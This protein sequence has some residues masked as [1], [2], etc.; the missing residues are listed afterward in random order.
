LLS[1]PKPSGRT[2]EARRIRARTRANA[3]S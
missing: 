2:H 3:S 1:P